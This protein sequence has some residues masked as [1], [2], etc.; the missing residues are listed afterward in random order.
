VFLLDLAHGVVLR[1]T[2][3]QAGAKGPVILA[4]GA[5]M[6]ASSWA[7]TTTSQSL[8]EALCAQGYDVWLFD[9]RGS[10]DAV[11]SQQSFCIDDIVRTDWPAAVD[12]VRRATRA[13]TVQVVG[14]CVGSMS[15]LM[16]LL[17]GLQGVRSVVSSQL[18]LHPL[19]Y[20]LNQAKTD[21]GLARMLEHSRKLGGLFCPVPGTT[22]ADR[23]LDVMAWSVPVPQG[24]ACKNPVCKRVNA[25]VGP[26][27]LHEQLNEETH[28]AM[29]EMFGPVSLSIF[30]Q[31]TLIMTRG[32]VVDALG[33]DTYL[34]ADNA[35]RMALP[36][37]FMSGGLNTLFKPESSLR[38]EAWLAQHNGP[39][40]YR[41]RVMEGYGHLDNFVGR[42][43]AR[44]VY[45]WVLAELERG[46]AS[47]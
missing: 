39:Q 17:A 43:A 26:V 24:Q 20:W 2:R 30:D 44:E 29:G 13:D 5:A 8:A 47:P 33:G 22:Q 45:P 14:H 35:R 23:E 34:T 46:D 3:Y 38:T 10:P 42:D 15:V 4:A 11:G 27:V 32:H 21:I 37:S 12:F 19:T 1:L 7:A 31:L 16:A 40:W 9:Y 25:F 18:T 41:R 28:F 6:R 36:I